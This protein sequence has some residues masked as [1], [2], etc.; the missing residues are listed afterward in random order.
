MNLPV[1][2]TTSA[3]ALGRPKPTHPR[4]PSTRPWPA[5]TAP[6]DQHQ[7]NIS[8]QDQNSLHSYAINTWFA[9]SC[10]QGPYHNIEQVVG[11]DHVHDPTLQLDH[12][13]SSS[14]K[15]SQ[16]ATRG[17]AKALDFPHA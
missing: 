1:K 15:G 17:S 2:K 10:N 14:C 12:L 11:G 7:D 6:N 16:V 13:A 4:N 9:E 5:S 3:S 8:L